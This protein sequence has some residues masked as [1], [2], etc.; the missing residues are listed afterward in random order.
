MKKRFLTYFHLGLFSVVIFLC[1]V[2]I[3]N[4]YSATYQGASSLYV[5]QIYWMLIGFVV[6]MLLVFID[7]RIFERFA[8]PLFGVGILMLILVLVFGPKIYGARRWIDIGLFRIQPSELMKIAM[9]LV[10]A[11][12]FHDDHRVGGY[13]WFQLLIPS[14]LLGLAV[15]L[16]MMEPDLGTALLFCF[17]GF[18]IFLFVKIRWQSLVIIAI[19]GTL[20]VP[21][22]YQFVLKEYQKER[23]KTFL[24]PGRDPRGKGYHALQSIIAVGSGRLDGKGHRKGTQTQLAFLPEQHTDF[25]FSVFAEEH[26]FIGVFILL[27]AYLSF[28]WM[29]LDISRRA[30]DKFGAV[31]A[32]GLTS[33]FFW[34]AVVNIGMVMGIMPVVGVTL[35][36]LSYGG[37][38]M[39]V[40]MA[41][42]GF[43]L[44]IHLRRFIF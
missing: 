28:L 23:V 17:I 4:L 43:L 22:A 1:I 13:T 10:L 37:S 8:Y 32:L 11:K 31:L 20:S 16:V 33:I 18:S 15:V 19:V 41:A 36:F 14:S 29:A 21:L 34:Q 24:N 25:I 6:M 44:S 5:A 26:G 12:Y 7:Y 9:A 30:R 42:V 27:M 39:I 3:F 38:S 2:G 40:S 35:P